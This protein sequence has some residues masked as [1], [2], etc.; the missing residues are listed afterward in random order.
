[1]CAIIWSFWTRLLNQRVDCY[2]V[3]Y[4]PEGQWLCRKCTAS[5]ENPVVRPPESCS[6]HTKPHFTI[7][8]VFYALTKEALVNKPHMANGAI[9]F[10]LYWSPKHVWRTTYSWNQSPVSTEYRRGAG[11][12]YVQYYPPRTFR[13]MYLW[14]EMLHMWRS[15]RSL[16][17]VQQAIM[18]P[19][20]PC[21]LCSQRETINADEVLSGVGGTFARRILWTTFTCED[22][23]FH[24]FTCANVSLE[25]TS[26]RARGSSQGRTYCERESWLR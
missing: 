26:R 19:R 9:Y 12:L 11:S 8:H 1:M 22:R 2:G 25:R 20:F 3:P 5:P 18:L 6:C 10:A 13:L 24:H 17:T 15:R 14:L 23:S 7:S 16:Y 21:H 4:I